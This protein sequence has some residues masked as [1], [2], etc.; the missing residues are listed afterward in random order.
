MHIWQFGNWRCPETARNGFLCD[1]QN[2][3]EGVVSF[4]AIIA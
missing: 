4:I 2:P 3:L 1:I